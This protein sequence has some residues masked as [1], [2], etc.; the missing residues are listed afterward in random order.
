MRKR[1]LFLRGKVYWY[2]FEL[3]GREYYHST[4]TSDLKL[5][6]EILSA[7]KE[8][9][10]LGKF[11]RKAAP[12]LRDVIKAWQATRGKN[13]ST[14]HQRAA[15]QS[16]E[17]L[18]PLHGMAINS[19]TPGVIDGWRGEFIL[20]HSAA[21]ANMR[22]RYLKL[23]LNWAQAEGYLRELPV[24]IKQPRVQERERPV[25]GL[26]HV[27]AFLEAVDMNHR[28][29]QVP[30]AVRFAMML[31]LRESEVLAARWEWIHGD[32]Y[33]VQ[34]KTKSKKIRRIPIPDRLMTA[35]GWML[36]ETE[37][38]T[39]SHQHRYRPYGQGPVPMPLL[40]LVFPGQD[41]KPHT[42]GWL[43]CALKRGAASMGI[44]QIGIHRLRATFATLHLR[45]GTPT[46]A[47]QKMMGHA[48]ARTTLIYHEVSKEEQAQAQGR[49]WG[50]K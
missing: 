30:A 19:I 33:V 34:G 7:T 32:E 6:K 41:G 50:V 23:W 47:V 43:R 27:E 1:E 10:L 40:G 14:S 21:T 8:D 24:K 16:A 2:R 3:N 13:V 48:D 5:A 35:L 20:N 18:K 37:W 26:T 25:V 4:K 44:D 36:L 12:A 46:K 15:R 49:L 42:Q 39:V 22:L 28:N 45:E 29:P 9:I 11:G 17:D 31:G 38:G